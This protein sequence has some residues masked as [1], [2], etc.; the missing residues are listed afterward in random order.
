M[1]FSSILTVLGAAALP[2]SEVRGAIPLAILKFDF[3]WYYALLFALIG[4]MLPVPFILLLL[5]RASNFLSKI[6]IFDRMFKWL[7]ERTR[8][9]GTIIE[10]YE[11]I[12]LMLF[13]AVPF[14]LTGAWT[15]A[16]AAVLVGIEFKHALLSIL[17]GVFI[18]GIIVTV[19]T[20]LG[21]IGA[22]IAGIGLAVIV[23]LGFWKS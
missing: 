21:W 23:A 22:L 11:R 15:G 4:N 6:I 18:A 16:I 5:N 14:P 1:D 3:P 7:F 13:V 10:R 12:G 20:L 9:K 17:A 19:L 2:I 8:R